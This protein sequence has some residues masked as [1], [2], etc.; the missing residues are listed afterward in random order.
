MIDTIVEPK[1]ISSAQFSAPFCMGM[2]L[3][4]GSCGLR[5]FV[6]ENLDD[7]MIL[8]IAHKVRVE[9]DEEVQSLYPANRGGR[10]SIR[11]SDGT[12]LTERV[13]DLK[14]SP[15]NPMTREE[16]E[17]KFYGLA[18]MVLPSERVLRV[19][20]VVRNLNEVDDIFSLTSLLVCQ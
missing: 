2:A 11:M 15:T 7:R 4:K 16:V 9:L 6:E 5:D 18:C 19:V 8:D 1:D 12:V 14:G 10:V 17:D 13:L 20:D 3:V